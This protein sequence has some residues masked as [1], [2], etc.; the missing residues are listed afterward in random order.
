MT[1]DDTYRALNFKVPLE[2]LPDNQQTCQVMGC[3]ELAAHTIF[4][5]HKSA[6]QELRLFLC[7]EHHTAISAPRPVAVKALCPIE[8]LDSI[9]MKHRSK[10]KAALVGEIQGYLLENFMR[11]VGEVDW[12]W[13]WIDYVDE[14]TSTRIYGTELIGAV[15]VERVE[16]YAP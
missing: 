3:Q 5:Q 7:G 12:D 10:M 16:I 9:P 1:T 6:P 15:N 14:R 2:G 4:F 11:P 13:H 8:H